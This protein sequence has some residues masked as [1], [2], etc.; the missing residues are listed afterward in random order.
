MQQHDVRLHNTQQWYTNRLFCSYKLC[1]PHWI[2]K[3]INCLWCTLLQ[4]IF[5]L[6]TQSFWWVAFAVMLKGTDS[7]IPGTRLPRHLK[8]VPRCTGPQCQACFGGHLSG[9]ENF[10]V[11]PR[12]LGWQPV[13][14]ICPDQSQFP[15]NLQRKGCQVF[16]AVKQ[17]E[18]GIVYT[19]PF[20]CQCCKWVGLISLP[21]LCAC[22]GM[23]WGDLYHHLDFW[24]ICAP[25]LNGNICV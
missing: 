10:E 4:H 9:T 3:P 1:V 25:L 20:L 7:H 16:P 15:P 22:T 17:P 18:R 19:T 2:N 14:C 8:F 11:A 24:K 6:L 5:F 12:Y 13:Q 23:S 21:S